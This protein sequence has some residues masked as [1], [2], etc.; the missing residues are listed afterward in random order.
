MSQKSNISSSRAAVLDAAE[1]LFAS[2]GYGAVTLKDISKKLGIKQASLYYHFPGGKE[3][4]F[5]EVMLRHLERR[6]ETLEQIIATES[7][8]LEGCLAKLAAWL[9]EQPPLN[10]NRIIH[11]DLTEINPQKAIQIE[12]AIG[13]CVHAP[14]KKLF[15]QY[16]P[17]LRGDPGFIAGIFLCGVE[18]LPT[19]QKYGNKTKD[20]MIAELIS[21]VLY[22][23]L[24]Q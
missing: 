6:R 11:T 17:Q 10:A 21:L 16:Q 9:W 23:A 7:K 22:G 2:Q 19:V 12:Q 8:T 24:V 14:V 18:P 20:E 15:A 3:D 4:L 1:H 5:V 13:R